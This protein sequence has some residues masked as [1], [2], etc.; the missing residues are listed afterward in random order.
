MFLAGW[1]NFWSPHSR[2]SAFFVMTETTMGWHSTLC[3]YLYFICCYLSS[4]IPRI[5]SNW[6]P[7]SQGIFN[8]ILVYYP[9]SFVTHSE[10]LAD[11]D[12]TQ[13]TISS[14][15]SIIILVV[16]DF[17]IDIKSSSLASS[18]QL[19]ILVSSYYLFQCV[20]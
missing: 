2:M 16:C 10:H 14:T 9:T 3:T 13:G 6:S 4:F 17:N 12:T 1:Y 18:R 7:N 15:F 11:P 8:C 5:P 19:E 20:N